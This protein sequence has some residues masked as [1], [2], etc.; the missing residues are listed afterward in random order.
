VDTYRVRT[1]SGQLRIRAGPGLNYAV[2]GGLVP[3]SQVQISEERS[4]WCRLHG[5]GQN[6][7]VSKEFLD[8]VSIGLPGGDPV[9]AIRQDPNYV[10]RRV[11]GAGIF[12]LGGPFRL[13]Q[14]IDPQ[15]G[16]GKR[17]FFME[18]SKFSIDRDPF[19]G[20]AQLALTS[21]VYTSEAAA[22]AAVNSS[23]YRRPGFVVYTHYRGHENII[24]P[25]II[26]TTTAPALIR[27]L[28]LALQSE[29]EYAK[30]AQGTLIEA[31]VTLG[32]LRYAP[33]VRAPAAAASEF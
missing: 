29:R 11:K 16:Q 6:G 10:E 13:D 12:G 17:S 26:T 7:W 32:G 5:S 18:R 25:T 1:D 9:A 27:A 19:V 24:F 23:P 21:T 30:A 4:G 2:V 3:G 31:F 20:S 33:R 8:R 14:E 28:N 22:T 15:T